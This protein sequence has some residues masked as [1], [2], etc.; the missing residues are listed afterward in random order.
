M[1]DS[2]FVWDGLEA[3]ED[4]MED[5]EWTG[6]E[7]TKASI[8]NIARIANKKYGQ[9]VPPAASNIGTPVLKKPGVPIKPTPKQKSVCSVI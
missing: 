3:L 8:A 7:S 6:P 1:C 2:L 5:I 9:K 4:A